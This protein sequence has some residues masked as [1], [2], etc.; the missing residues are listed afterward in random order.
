[1]VGETGALLERKQSC[2][3]GAMD[4]NGAV[5]EMLCRGTWLIPYLCYK[6]IQDSWSCMQLADVCMLLPQACASVA[7]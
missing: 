6:I 2:N 3:S 1:M 4:S 7:G 5:P